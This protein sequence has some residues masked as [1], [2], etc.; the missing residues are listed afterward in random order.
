MVKFADYTFDVLIEYIY[1]QGSPQS[2]AGCFPT[3]N[4]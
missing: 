1:R 2:V 3:V 4:K